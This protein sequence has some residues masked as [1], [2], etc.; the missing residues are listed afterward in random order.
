MKTFHFISGKWILHRMWGVRWWDKVK[1][2]D[3]WTLTEMEWSSYR[4]WSF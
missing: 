1:H 2:S 4:G 3:A